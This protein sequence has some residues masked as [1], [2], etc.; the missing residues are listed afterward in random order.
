MTAAAIVA[1]IASLLKLIPEMSS[2]WAILEKLL[3]TGAEP[4]AAD[5][6]ALWTA[7]AAAHARVQGV[8]TASTTTAT[9]T[10][11]AVKAPASALA[12]LAS[13]AGVAASPVG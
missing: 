4:T 9:V 8:T 3:T 2:D 10:S 11:A 6:A 13:P 12:I 5:M 1:L 7:A